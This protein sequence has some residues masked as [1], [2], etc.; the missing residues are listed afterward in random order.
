LIVLLLWLWPRC[1][2]RRRAGRYLQGDILTNG[3]PQHCDSKALD[4]FS[5]E[6][7]IQL[8]WRGKA[9]ANIAPLESSLKSFIVG[10]VLVL[11]R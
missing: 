5:A 6:A 7:V 4:D 9:V 11:E 8:G 2:I 3:L 10:M 1:D